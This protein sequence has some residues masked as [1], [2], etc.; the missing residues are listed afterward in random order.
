[1]SAHRCSTRCRR[2]SPRK[3]RNRPGVKVDKP[4]KVVFVVRIVDGR[5]EQFEPTKADTDC[6]IQLGMADA[7]AIL[8]GSLERDVAFMRGDLKIDGDYAA[9]LLRLQPLFAS[10]EFENWRS[11]VAKQTE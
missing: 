10:A 2:K 3:A 7:R 6:A 5:V 4:E 11:A 1:M 8:D 9:Y